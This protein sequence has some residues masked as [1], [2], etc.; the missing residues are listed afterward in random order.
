MFKFVHKKHKLFRRSNKEHSYQITV[1]PDM[2]FLRYLKFHPI[3]KHYWP[4]RYVEFLNERK[5]CKIFLIIFQF[6]RGVLCRL[7]R[8]NWNI[9]ESGDKHYNTNPFKI[10][11]TSK[12]LLLPSLDCEKKFTCWSK[13]QIN[14][15]EYIL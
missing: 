7:S 13:L 12:V 10:L 15:F 6:Y 11:R 4:S 5:S 14:K 2:W 9:V 3:K 8:Y 1:P